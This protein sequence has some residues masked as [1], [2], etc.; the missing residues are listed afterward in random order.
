MTTQLI[1]MGSM[2][3]AAL[4]GSAGQIF[5][6]KGAGGQLTIQGLVTN[7]YLWG[8]VATYGCAV[9][10]NLGAYR[11]GG[12]VSLLYPVISLSYIFSAFLAWKILGENVS[13]YTWA[14][15]III[16]LGVSIIGFGATQ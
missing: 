12:K 10:I 13:T 14:G 2:I 8:F 6:N 5:L 1:L 9:L 7:W 3:I 16:I 11:L 15:T 4:L